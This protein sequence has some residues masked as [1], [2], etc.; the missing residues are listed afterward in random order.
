MCGYWCLYYLNERQSGRSILDTI[1]NP[2]FDFTKLPRERNNEF[3]KSYFMKGRFI[4]IKI[5]LYYMFEKL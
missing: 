4:S 2:E 5:F 1:H 3:I